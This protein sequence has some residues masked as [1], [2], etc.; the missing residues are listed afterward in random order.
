MQSAGARR[1]FWLALSLL[2]LTLIAGLI[3]RAA[4]ASPAGQINCQPAK[5]V[6][7]PGA[8]R[9]RSCWLS[10]AR[11]PIPAILLSARRSISFLSRQ[12]MSPRG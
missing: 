2:T 10:V 6:Y 8:E 12:W 4:P 5:S 3:L 7:G 1:R 11:P 9:F